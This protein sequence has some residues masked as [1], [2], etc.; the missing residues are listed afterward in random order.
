MTETQ[1]ATRIERDSMGEMEVPVD[2]LYG[3]STQRAVLNF[4]ISG[5]RMPRR[6]LRALALIKLA[7]AETNA[8]LG[9]LDPDV[10]AA[11]ARRRTRGRRRCP[12]R[13]VPDRHLPD[14]LGHLDQHEHERGRRA[15]RQRPPRR[16]GGPPERRRQPLPELQRHDP[17]G[18]PA[19]G[20]D[21]DRG[22]AAA[23][24]RAAPHRA[25]REGAGALAGRQDR[26][27]APPGRD[28]DPARTGVP[29]LRRTGRGVAP[30]RARRPG[31]AAG[32]PA[33][34]DRG[35]DRDQRPS[36]VRLPGLRAAVVP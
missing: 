30:A 34:R 12:R 9:L 13:P 20:R 26:S 27:D 25:R 21:G 29:R 28:A 36:R 1:P 6:F 10:A 24:A 32:G 35:R 11:I 23:C 31:R 16:S 14:G 19:L 8:G 5:E 4:P 33:R 15:P 22:G 7:A 3:A 2:A 18:A 17:D